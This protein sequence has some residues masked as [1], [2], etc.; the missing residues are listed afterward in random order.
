MAAETA[1]PLRTLG[2][3]VPAEWIDYNG[4]VL[5]ACYLLAFAPATTAL[6]DALD[7]GEAY[8]A[9]TGCTI[10]T[11]ECHLRYLR[12]LHGGD[13]PHLETWLLDADEKRIHAYHT[14]ATAPGEEPA[15]T[16]ELLF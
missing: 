9:R 13:V 11:A 5:D 15:A 16:C 12:E 6:L 14:L 10:Y 2:D 8:R 3:P 4:H 7:L 1:A